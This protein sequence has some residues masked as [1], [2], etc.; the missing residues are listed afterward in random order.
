MGHRH[1]FNTPQIVKT[2]DD[3]G[4]N[5][6]EQPYVPIA[7]VASESSSISYPVDSM[8]IQ[9]GHFPSQWT[10]ASRSSGYSSSMLNGEL[11]HYQAVA[12]GPS[13][14]P[15]LHQPTAGNLH[16]H[17]DNYS[18][19]PSSSN[20]GGQ[21]VHG[22]DSGFYDQTIVSGKGPYKRKS[23]GVTLMCDSG[24]TSRYYGAESSSDIHL[25]VDPWQEKQIAESYHTNWEYPPSYG[26]NTNFVGSEGTL[27]NIRSRG[28][29]D[30]ETNLV[31][32]HL[33]N[34]VHHSS[35]SQSSDHSN[36]R[37]FWG[38]NLN[39]PARD[40]NRNLISP[41]ADGVSFGSNPSFF[42]QDP[43]Y[44]NTL[45][46]HP[47]GS[48]EIGGTNNDVSNRNHI[49]EN[50]SNNLNQS[51]R[52]V[53]SDYGQRSTSTFRASSSN[54]SSGYL[55]ASDEGQQMVAKSYPSR[56]P[57]PS[58]N[59]RLRNVDR[60]GRNYVS[61]ERYRGSNVEGVVVMDHSSYYGSRSM[62][63]QHRD[64]RLDIDNMSYEELLALGE[65]MG[66]VSTGLSDGLISK[67]LTE[68]IYCS[69]DLFQDDGTCVICLE[70]YRNVDDVGTLRVC[71]H[72]FH[73]AC[74][75]KWLLLKNLCPICKAPAIDDDG[76][77]G[78]N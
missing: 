36:S 39:V 54:F 70:E 66:S 20:M 48:F 61:S 12:S 77:K 23:P 33:P 58:S 78:G 45:H 21:T 71:G 9:G 76:T 74:I 31:R 51:V 67:S 50:V 3:Q 53:R 46:N 65:R 47:N 59:L 64:M 5:Y 27:R 4:W 2:D 1:I 13:H 43:S 10:H 16:M 7:R 57:R 34:S 41:T 26:V 40:W 35:S 24:S 32:T 29:V 25:P 15:F 68:S 8:T 73:V 60:I 69:S 19:H 37:D 30:L 49:P 52:G 56:H 38:Q 17:Q 22:V 72:D 44:L 28:A 18:H 11:P 14:D 75:R 62:V 63:D 55:A 6:A 42:S